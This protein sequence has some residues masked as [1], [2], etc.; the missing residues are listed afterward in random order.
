M[1]HASCETEEPGRVIRID[2][3]APETEC[4]TAAFH[5]TVGDIFHMSSALDDTRCACACDPAAAG[6]NS[7][8][9]YS[10]HGI[11]L[12]NNHFCRVIT[13]PIKGAV[14]DMPPDRWTLDPLLPRVR[15]T[16]HTSRLGG[17]TS[18]GCCLSRISPFRRP[19]QQVVCGRQLCIHCCDHVQHYHVH[20]S[21]VPRHMYH[22]VFYAV[23]LC[24]DG[25]S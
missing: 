10:R 9:C 1:A 16:G 4:S 21:V 20:T 24:S 6:H 3:H 11:E 25:H 17:Q 2:A 13:C 14:D 23:R 18:S 22:V 12:C 5:F 15:W 7:W 19:E 8:C